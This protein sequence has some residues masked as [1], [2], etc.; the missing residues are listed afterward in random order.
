MEN[1]PCIVAVDVFRRQRS[2]GAENGDHGLAPVRNEGISLV[3]WMHDVSV[4]PQ[5][6]YARVGCAQ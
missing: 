4:A 5:R 2:L 6:S 1:S 3:P